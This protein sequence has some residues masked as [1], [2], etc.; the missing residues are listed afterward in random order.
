MSL[1]VI[2]PPAVPQLF[3]HRHRVALL[4]GKYA[5]QGHNST[6]VA[7]RA[8]ATALPGYQF[9]YWGISANNTDLLT[10]NPF[11]ITPIT[12]GT[13]ISL[14]EA[15][16]FN[17]YDYNIT[18]TAH[19]AAPAIQVDAY[20][21]DLSRL[22]I[23]GESVVWRHYWWWAPGQHGS[24]NYPTYLNGFSWLP[25][26]QG[27]PFFCNGCYSSE[28]IGIPGLYDEPL[29]TY[30]SQLIATSLTLGGSPVTRQSTISIFQM[31]SA[32]NNYTL[33]VEFHDPE[34]GAVWFD[35]DIFYIPQ[36][37]VFLPSLV[38]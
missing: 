9:A 27:N 25:L 15:Y 12:S 21:D 6:V 11:V 34:A 3:R 30:T 37:R 32:T 28:F 16:S 29:Q 7:V 36:W 19:F 2:L 13:V 38:R 10:L 4:N 33:V 18:L 1:V 14:E 5:G 17:L 24:N 22:Y 23:Q 8:Q 26:W 35:V 31:P 20:I